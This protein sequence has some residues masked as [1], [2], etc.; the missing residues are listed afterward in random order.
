M[1]KQERADNLINFIWLDIC[2]KIVIIMIMKKVVILFLA[3]FIFSLQSYSDEVTVKENKNDL[4]DIK[5]E[6]REKAEVEIPAGI[7]VP[8]I[9]MQEVST[10]TC[11]EGYKV[12]FVSTNDLYIGDIKVIPEDTAFYGYIEKINE[13]I[14]GTNASMKV[15]VTKLVYP[16]GYEQNIK[17]Y[18]YT[19]NDNLIG[20]DLTEPAEWVRMPHYQDKYQGIAWIHRGATLQMRPGGRRSMGQHTK[21][22]VGERHL[23]IFAAPAHIT[24]MISE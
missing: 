8:V 4:P 20:G 18:I 14:V 15:K 12:K 13:P 21:L 1:V 7:V 23:V 19:S 2:K 3:I 6:L 17:A 5:V 11:P 16:D 24:H 10:E 22:P 9:N